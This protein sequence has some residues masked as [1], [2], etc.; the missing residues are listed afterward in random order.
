MREI[1]IVK[2]RIVC[3]MYDEKINGRE[4]EKN[5]RTNINLQ[6]HKKKQRAALEFYPLLSV[7]DCTHYT[8]PWKEEENSREREE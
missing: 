6:H 2:L 3:Q 7:T 1:N 5:H 4:N 8:F